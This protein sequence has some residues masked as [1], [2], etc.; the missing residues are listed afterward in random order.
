M[1][2]P[3]IFLVHAHRI[4]MDP[5]VDAF[6]TRWPEA[7]VA[8]LL[9]DSLFADFGRDGG[10]TDAMVERFRSIGRYCV[11][12][13]ADA[14]LF[15]CSAFGPAID[16]V[17]RDHR[18]PVLKPNEALYDEMAEVSA[19]GGSVLLLAT[20]PPTLPAMLDEIA[21]HAAER[22][23]RSRI[24][25]RM[26][27]GA[28]EALQSGDMETHDRR[29]VEASADPAGCDAIAWGQISMA[30]A[31]ARMA[32]PGRVPILT[33]PDGSIRKLRSLL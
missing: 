19:R 27:E 33:T 12:A 32:G 8:N 13:G 11:Q 21:T 24:T 1:T 14:I 7:R 9:E 26:V 18:I 23:A 30:P 5:I 15:T 2:H 10:L 4:S 31:L 29:I 20:F 28:L 16:A 3:K 22:G 6:A 25:T 17:K